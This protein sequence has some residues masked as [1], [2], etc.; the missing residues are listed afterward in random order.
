MR[1]QRSCRNCRFRGKDRACR[2]IVLHAGGRSGKESTRS[3]EGPPSDIFVD[4][5]HMKASRGFEESGGG[6]R[7]GGSTLEQ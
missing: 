2:S 1:R 4:D 3:F 6:A 5:L 7:N